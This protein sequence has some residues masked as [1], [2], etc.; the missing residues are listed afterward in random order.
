MATDIALI[1]CSNDTH[2][3]RLFGAGREKAHILPDGWTSI[4]NADDLEY[5]TNALAIW[6]YS[7]PGASWTRNGDNWVV[8]VQQQQKH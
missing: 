6:G 1:E 2:Q 5:V 4:H 8:P 3:W 7:V